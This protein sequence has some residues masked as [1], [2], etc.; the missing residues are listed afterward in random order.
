MSY[1]ETL[2]QSFERALEFHAP[3]QTAFGFETSTVTWGEFGERVMQLA[4]GLAG[5][6]VGPRSVV[7]YSL[8]NCPDAIALIVA[9]S[10]L[11]ARA[12]P[13]FPKIPEPIRA[14]VFSAFG[15]CVVLTSAPSVE[16]LKQALERMQSSIPVHDVGGLG[17]AHHAQVLP[18]YEVRA[19]EPFLAAA[20]SGTTGVPKSVWI[21]HDNVAA[22]LSATTDLAKLGDW[23]DG[24]YSTL[25]AFPLSTSSVLVVLG[26]LFAG[27]HLVFA[28]DLRPTH[29]VEIAAHWQVDSLSAPPAYFEAILTLPRELVPP[30]PRVRAIFTGMDFLHPSLLSRLKERL[31]GLDRAAS[32]YGLVETSTIFMTWKAHDLEQMVEPL[33]VFTLCPSV[34]NQIDVRDDS[35]A[36]VGDGAEGELWVKGPSVVSGYL[37]Q[38]PGSPAFVDGWFRTGDAARRV[39]A[40]R[41]ELCG[42]RKY[43]IKR[44]GKSVSPIEVQDR[45]DACKGVRT[46]AVVGVKHPLYG[47]MIWAFVVSERD[48]AVTLTD[49]MRECRAN[50]PVHMVPD[51]VTFVSELPRGSGVGKLDRESL[52]R[53]AEAELSAIQGEHCD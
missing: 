17:A 44:G 25:M 51:Q 42:R 26:M 7:G 40:T 46:S 3:D 22:I 50:L 23:V 29:Y 5:Q 48:G 2:N 9:I 31:P 47:E 39:D 32:G 8:P 6:G 18:A 36:S 4:R 53:M 14:R 49:L 24:S 19:S 28:E 45:L 52:I 37:G 20:S 34:A 16:G 21:T 38:Q 35:G 1:P 11:G 15:C 13:L 41:I 10:R 27:A 30:L 12:V 33:N 43:L